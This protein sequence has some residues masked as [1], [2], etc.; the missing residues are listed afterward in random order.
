MQVIELSEFRD[1]EGL[2]S[3]EN[4][5]RGTVRFGFNWFGEM[6]AQE[7][8]TR[9][10]EGI[11]DDDHM[12]ILNAPLVGTDVLAPLIL[13]S[14]QGVRLLYPSTVRGN[15]RAQD[16]KWQTYSRGQFNPKKPN[17]Q[18]RALAFARG[19]LRYFES[20]GF[21]LPDLEAV[22]MFTNPQTHVDTVGPQARIVLADAFEHFAAKIL[23][24]GTIM[25]QE[26]IHMLVDSLLN[27]KL[28][29][30][31]QEVEL[32]ESGQEIFESEALRPRDERRD[33]K[34][35]RRIGSFTTRQWA[36]LAVLGAFQLIIMLVIAF[37]VLGDIIF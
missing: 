23:E 27:P 22:L 34:P 13:F 2:I 28:P 15:F 12:L 20:Q 6:H 8:V 3:L 21:P 4:R 10:L 36:L 30:P 25:D 19:L 16:D 33:L 11:L 31:E 9:K 14:P 32:D 29:E 18:F 24:G 1:E 5:V 17:L 7:L 35:R 37:I 26:D